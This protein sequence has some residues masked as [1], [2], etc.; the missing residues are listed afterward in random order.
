MKYIWKQMGMANDS[1]VELTRKLFEMAFK[2]AKILQPLEDLEQRVMLVLFFT[3]H[4]RLLNLNCPL[5]S[6]EPLKEK[7]IWNL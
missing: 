3:L 1:F 5:K 7:S 2:N 6:G 4:L